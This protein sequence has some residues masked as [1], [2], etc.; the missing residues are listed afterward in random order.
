M[1]KKSFLLRQDQEE[2]VRY[3]AYFGDPN[4]GCA[5]FASPMRL[6]IA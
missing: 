6:R 4:F 5:Y 3:F 1:N 2:K